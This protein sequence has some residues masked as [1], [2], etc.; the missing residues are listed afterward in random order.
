MNRYLKAIKAAASACC[1]HV[2]KPALDAILDAALRGYKAGEIDVLEF[3]NVDNEY[4][5]ILIAT[6]AINYV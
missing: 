5:R 2:L 6:N 4:T 1:L 3:G